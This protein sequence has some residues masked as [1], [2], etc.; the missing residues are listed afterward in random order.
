MPSDLF[1]AEWTFQIDPLRYFGAPARLVRGP[2][3]H[4]PLATLSRLRVCIQTIRS[5]GESQQIAVWK[6]LYWIQHLDQ[7]ASRM[8]EILRPDIEPE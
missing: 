8:Q 3:G 2:Q 1:F 4:P 7:Y 6:L 5:K